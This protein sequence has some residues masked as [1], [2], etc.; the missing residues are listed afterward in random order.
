MS[1]FH[2]V[3]QKGVVQWHMT[4]ANEVKEL[5]GSH[6]LNA[7]ADRKFKDR[8]RLDIHA[9]QSLRS[10]VHILVT[11]D[12]VLLLKLNAPIPVR[13]VQL[14]RAFSPSHI[15]VRAVQWTRALSLSLKSVKRLKGLGAVLPLPVEGELGGG[16]GAAEGVGGRGEGG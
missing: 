1:V 7:L 15:P 6:P 3:P 5:S 16:V 8:C 4:K 2:G 10:R 13:R 11:L 12:H 14:T 9:S